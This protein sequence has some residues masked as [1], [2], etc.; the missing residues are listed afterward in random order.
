MKSEI[1]FHKP[2]VKFYATVG[3]FA[4]VIVVAIVVPSM[5]LFPDVW[6]VGVYGLFALGG[7]GGLGWAARQAQAIRQTGELHSLAVARARYL[8]IPKAS[9]VIDLLEHRPVL[10]GAGDALCVE[11]QAVEVEPPRRSVFD[12]LADGP[13][14]ALIGGTNSGKTTLANHLVEAMAT[15]NA[16]AYALDPDAKFNV[17]SPRCQVVDDYA[18]IETTLH[19]HFLEMERRRAGGPDSY[20]LII[21]AM[22]EWPAVVDE[23]DRAGFYLKRLSRQGRKVGFR[24]LLLSQSDLVEDI[25]SNSSVKENFIKIAMRP[26]LV[27][28]N[29]AVI[30]HW[31]RRT[32]LITLAGTYGR[33]GRWFNAQPTALALPEVE[34]AEVDA[35]AEFVELVQGGLSKS[36]ASRRVFGKPFAGTSHVSRL[37]E[38]LLLAGA[39]QLAS[40]Q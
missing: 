3:L 23:C 26:D 38:A 13:H 17:W 9:H 2:P 27:R 35:L 31:D 7:L 15:G 14:F 32:E 40:T 37:N 21:I 22:D 8:V 34:V 28:Q 5:I 29:L 30:K 39:A 1:K 24:L 25:G 16:A 18:E 6:R 4:A 33:T 19:R 36:E 11:G 12:L 10:L 20:P